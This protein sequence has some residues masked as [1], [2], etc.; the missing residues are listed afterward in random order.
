MRRA[1]SAA[2]P[3][4]VMISFLG[5]LEAQMREHPEQIKPLDRTLLEDIGELVK[6]VKTG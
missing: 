1:K 2:T 5:F 3:D 4:P 6:G